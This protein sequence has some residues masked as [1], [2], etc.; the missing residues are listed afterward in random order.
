MYTLE[1]RN[2]LYRINEK[3]NVT[4]FLYKKTGNDYVKSEGRLW[5]MILAG[6]G[7]EVEIPVSSID[8]EFTAS[9]NDKNLTLVYGSIKVR[10]IP[11]PISV[12]IHIQLENDS[13]KVWSSIENNDEELSVMEIFIS[14]ASGVR[15]IAGNSA[16]DALAWPYLMGMK[17]KNP[18]FS[19]LSVYSG[20]RKYERHDQFHTDL[21]STYPS[22]L[23][24]KWF[25]LYCP[26]EGLYIASHGLTANTICM[27]VERDV[28][29]NLLSLGVCRY[30]F[31]GYGERQESEV[32]VY[33]PHEGDWHAG[34]RMYRKFMTS[35]GQWKKDESPSWARDFTGWLRIIFQPQHCEPN[36][37]FHD[38]P[39]LY[40]QAESC[41]IKTLFI[42]GW[43]QEGFARQWPDYVVS[44]DLGGE[45]YL[46]K[47]I[48]YIHSKGGK[49]IMFLSYSLIDHK[50]DFYINGPGKTCTI[51]N[52]WGEEIPFAE[53]Y[54]GEGTYRKI[55]NPPMPMYLACPGSDEWQRK[56]LASADACLKFG[57][58]GVLYDLG[59]LPAYFCFDKHHDHRI[60][61]EA[62]ESKADRYRELH[63]HIHDSGP[64]RIILMEHCVDIFNQH[65]DVVHGTNHLKSENEFI[66]LYRYTFPEVVMTN[67]ESG[68]DDS[69]YRNNC[70][71][72]FLYGLRFD[73]TIFR[74]CGTFDDIPLYRAYLKQ[75]N[76]IRL[77]HRDT[78]LDGCFVDEFGFEIND[79]MADGAPVSYDEGKLKA[80]SYMST[81]GK[82][83]VV[84]WNRT[85]LAMD[86][87]LT[88]IG[89][90]CRASVHI[91]AQSIAVC[92]N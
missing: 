24:M 87:S 49:V 45:D 41:G 58:D 12:I 76:E 70:N 17:I 86:I 40:D 69:D 26:T 59:G 42:M 2:I 50:S 22:R 92:E 8:Q 77:A 60:P 15:S 54:C 52:A 81:S 31:L 57:C 23:S 9:C 36:F 19:D 7:R 3:G 38:I 85:D 4:S 91:S 25:D 79:V 33:Q 32:T 21:D 75:L 89:S 10:G 20:F 37:T 73:M 5:K 18:A 83:T 44:S 51:K 88:F 61:S 43:E 67:R 1:G 13:L 30:P 48:E 27:H 82:L 72:T 39:R 71:K 53:T 64:D 6:K 62:Y 63:A 29:A 90:G 14:A 16:D 46:R 11:R 65:M 74:C 78:L 68:E 34:A 35:T 28:K 56:M 47:G 84:L 66:E 80:K 55:T